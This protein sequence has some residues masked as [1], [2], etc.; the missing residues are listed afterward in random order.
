MNTAS[1]VRNFGVTEKEILVLHRKQE[2]FNET[3]D[4]L[5]R[6]LEREREREREKMHD[7]KL[8]CY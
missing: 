7:D 3:V 2:F 8:S 4:L 1:C 5:I 6:F